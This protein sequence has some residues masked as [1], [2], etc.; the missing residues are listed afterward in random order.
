MPRFRAALAVV[1]R[2]AVRARVVDWWNESPSYAH[3]QV[4][5]VLCVCS[6]CRAE[7]ASPGG[8]ST[9]SLTLC[10]LP[11]AAPFIF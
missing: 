6:E 8:C 3:P 2:V 11:G 1:G 4:L 9:W 5:F 10:V 7:A